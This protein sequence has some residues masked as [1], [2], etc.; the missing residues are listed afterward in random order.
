MVGFDQDIH[1]HFSQYVLSHFVI[2]GYESDYDSVILGIILDNIQLPISSIRPDFSFDPELPGIPS[3][4]SCVADIFNDNANGTGKMKIGFK[5]LACPGAFVQYRGIPGM[6]GR[7][8]GVWS[9]LM[10]VRPRATFVNAV[11]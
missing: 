10:Q 4:P 9:V 7:A 1:Y 5:Y 2:Q 3:S 6:K 8:L 11:N